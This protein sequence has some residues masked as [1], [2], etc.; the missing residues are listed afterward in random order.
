[1]AAL[2]RRDATAATPPD[3]D[4]TIAFDAADAGEIARLYDAL[5]RVSDGHNPRTA[6]L[7]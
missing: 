2:V 5:D 7:P 3:D 6:R 1:M 4:A